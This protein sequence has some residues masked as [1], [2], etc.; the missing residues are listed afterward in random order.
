[1]T[2]S[3]RLENEGGQQSHSLPLEGKKTALLQYS[4]EHFARRP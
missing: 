1:M 2:T 4:S 3:D